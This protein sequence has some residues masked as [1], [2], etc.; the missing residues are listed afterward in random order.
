MVGADYA[1]CR[2]EGHSHEEK[3]GKTSKLL[4]GVEGRQRLVHE[5]L[6]AWLRQGENS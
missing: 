6:L 3:T 5:K 4:F 2:K 1:G